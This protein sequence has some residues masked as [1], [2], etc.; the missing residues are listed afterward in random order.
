MPDCIDV[1]PLREYGVIDDFVCI[2]ITENLRKDG[3]HR[4]FAR[5]LRSG[6]CMRGIHAR[7]LDQPLQPCHNPC[8]HRLILAV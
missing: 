6:S 1:V 8:F 3:H 5:R 2:Q 4:P 7:D